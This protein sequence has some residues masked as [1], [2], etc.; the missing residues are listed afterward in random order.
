MSH[1]DAP[2]KV[3]F[4]EEADEA[5]SNADVLAITALIAIAVVMI[6]FYVSQ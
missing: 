5:N 2:K 6:V 3:Q 4:N 1:P